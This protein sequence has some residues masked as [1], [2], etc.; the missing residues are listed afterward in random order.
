MAE[1]FPFAYS[2]FDF[3]MTFL[4]LILFVADVILDVQLV[5]VLY[6][7]NAY[8]FMGVVVFLLLASSLLVQ[9][10]SWLWFYYDSKSLEPHAKNCIRNEQII[11][12]THVL[13][14]GIPLRYINMLDIWCRSNRGKNR[15]LECVAVYL[16]HDLSMLRLFETF[17]ESAPQLVL[18][19]VIT[20]HRNEFGFIPSLKAVGSAAAI[21]F[22]VVTY[23]RAMRSFLPRKNQQGCGSSVVY[24]VWNLLLIGPRVAALALFACVLPYYVA[25]HFIGLWLPLVLWAGLQKTD[26]MD[27]LAGERL[28]RA[29]IGLILYFT[30]FNIAKGSSLGRSIIYHAFIM[31]DM[32]FLLGAW[33]Y[34]QKEQWDPRV[35]FSAVLLSYILGLVVKVFYYRYFHPKKTVPCTEVYQPQPLG[36]MVDFRSLPLVPESG[37]TRLS[38]QTAEV[39]PMVNKRMKH[40]AVNFY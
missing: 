14:L 19:T 7:E 12:T 11:A 34:W 22:S 8:A 26:F 33:W 10:F 6:K 15:Y 21:T 2:V 32:G 37:H 9:L 25:V 35:I 39:P 36:D 24:F 5:V 29:A 18:M 40:L 38:V 17:S 27:S 4:G 23:H 28:Y 1:G 13:Q 31:A 3:S 30:W 20:I 16:T